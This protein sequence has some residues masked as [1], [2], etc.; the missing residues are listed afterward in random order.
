MDIDLD[1][2]NVFFRNIK[3]ERPMPKSIRELTLERGYKITWG[4]LETDVAGFETFKHHL[5]KEAV[6]KIN[7]STRK[8]LFPLVRVGD[9]TVYFAYN[10]KTGECLG[11]YS[12]F[13]REEERK[14]LSRFDGRQ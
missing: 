9:T 4:S 8:K 2:I 3:E 14:F 6:R 1:E 7:R 11:G 5:D 10:P 12:V 13:D